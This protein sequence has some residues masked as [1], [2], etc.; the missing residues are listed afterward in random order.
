MIKQFTTMFLAVTTAFWGGG[1]V[2]EGH[3][4]HH[5]P[6]DIDAFHALLAPIWHAQPGPARSR[7]ACAKVAEM[8]AGARDIRSTDATSLVAAIAA[9]KAKCQGPQAEVDVALFDVHEAFHG[10]IDHK[11]PAA[12]R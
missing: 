11:P 10:L 2:A 3:M 6:K 7:N 9:L 8:E 5:F 12:M 4:H 1:A